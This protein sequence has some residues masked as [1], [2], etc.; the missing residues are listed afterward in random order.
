MRKAWRQ[1]NR[2]GQ[3]VASRTVEHLMQ[4]MGLQGVMRGKPVKTTVSD[5]ADTMPAGPSQAPVPGTTTECAVG[6][7]FQI[8]RHPGE[9]RYEC[10]LKIPQVD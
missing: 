1:L 7:G 9:V 10:R 3:D 6:F 5:E 2:E 4:T 8:R